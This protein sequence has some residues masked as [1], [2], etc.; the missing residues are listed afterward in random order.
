MAGKLLTPRQLEVAALVAEEGLS[1]AGIAARL[2]IARST[3]CTYLR[4]VR[5]RSGARDRAGLAR[6]LAGRPAG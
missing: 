3:A 2:G 1:A 4:A 5:V 6:W